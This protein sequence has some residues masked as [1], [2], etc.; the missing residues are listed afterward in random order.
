[1]STLSTGEVSTKLGYLVT[2]QFIE[3]MGIK[4]AEVVKGHPRWASTDF[5]K[6]CSKIANHTH[7]VGS[8][9]ELALLE[10][11]PPKS[12]PAV[13]PYVDDEDEL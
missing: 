2:R 9:H 3:K 5:P 12:E 8:A 6:L 1:M 11:K 4:P 7:G 10:A 13:A